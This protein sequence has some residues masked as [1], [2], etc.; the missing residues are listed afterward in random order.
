MKT[1]SVC[2]KCNSLNQVDSEKAKSKRP[3]CGK[4]QS[5]LPMHSLVSEVDASA[6]ERIL[7]KADRPVIVDFWASWCGPCKMYGPEF[8]KAS[9]MTD[10]AIFLK[11]NTETNQALSAKLGIRSIP[12]TIIF[13]QGSEIKRQP[14][15]LSASGVVSL[16]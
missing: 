6:L 12:T 10:K 11:I 16:I 1:L 2:Q 3:T 4:C 14:G 8:E 5:E 13:N 15:A 7:K 9:T